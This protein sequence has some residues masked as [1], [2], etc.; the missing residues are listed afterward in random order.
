LRTATCLAVATGGLAVVI[1]GWAMLQNLRGEPV[2]PGWTTNM[3][4]VALARRRCS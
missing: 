4:L 3:M 1:A 2:T